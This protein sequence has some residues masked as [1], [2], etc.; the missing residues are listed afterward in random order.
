MLEREIQQGSTPE[1]HLSCRADKEEI[2]TALESVSDNLVISSRH[3]PFLFLAF[4]EDPL[5]CLYLFY[6]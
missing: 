3:Q 6:P 1:S 5:Y 2:F 4:P